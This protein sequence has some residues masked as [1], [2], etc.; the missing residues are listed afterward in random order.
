MVKTYLGSGK[1]LTVNL[2]DKTVLYVEDN[3]T[4]QFLMEMIFQNFDG[5]KLD[6]VDD[7]E[8]GVVY[9]SSC[10]P[11]LILIDK[12]LPKMNG[13]EFVAFLKSNSAYQNIPTIMLT[14]D[15]DDA[16]KR[17]G[18]LVG[19]DFVEAKPFDIAK[20]MATIDELI[21]H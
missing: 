3:A 6:V 19:C 21:N 11:D 7:A 10:I 8:Q 14:A 13:L 15:C 2:S 5:F 12:N 20:L 18:K 17:E 1:A 4:N 16:T 9:V